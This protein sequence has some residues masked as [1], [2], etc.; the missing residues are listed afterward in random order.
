[1]QRSRAIRSARACAALVLWLASAG[2][3]AAQATGGAATSNPHIGLVL[4]GAYA[5]FSSLTP[6][7]VPGFSLGGETGPGDPGLQ[8]G[9]SEIGMYGNIDPYLYGS[10]VFSFK[11]EGSVDVEEGFI[12]STA[13]PGGFV[14]KAGRFF[15]GIGY[16]NSQHRHADDFY[17]APL[18]Y[19]VFLGGQLGDDGVEVRWLAP[20]DFLLEFGLDRYRGDSFPAGGQANQ[21]SGTGVGYVRV[22]GDAGISSSWLAS[23]GQIHALSVARASGDATSPDL[24]TGKSTVSLASFIWKWAPEGN[25]TYTNFK[26]QAEYFQRTEDGAYTLDSLGTPVAVDVSGANRARQTGWYAQA[27]YQ[28]LERWRVAARQAVVHADALADPAAAGTALDGQGKSP[29]ITSA[30]IEYDT[31]EFGQLRLQYSA[32][33]TDPS[34]TIGR[35]FLQYIVTLGSHAAHT[36]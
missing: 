27:R 22:G 4:N 10:V 18:P 17:D 8:L 5:H 21:G 1:M 7:S 25:E 19:Q 35:W 23:L 3:L 15:S 12:Q 34:Q 6:F 31:S 26:V 20:T 36:Y 9:E 30:M 29:S 13:L 14:L 24:F 33:K 11:P 28:F 32:D 16:L 2:T